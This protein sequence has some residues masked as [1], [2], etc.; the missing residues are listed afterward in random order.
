MLL[1]S[2]TDQT[3]ITE[4]LEVREF[5]GGVG[6]F[7]TKEIR[8]NE[9]LM[10]FDCKAGVTRRDLRKFFPDGLMDHVEKVETPFVFVCVHV[11]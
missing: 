1:K 8:K 10:K 6:L 9:L 5:F 11:L 7:A 4:D 2:G 3:Y